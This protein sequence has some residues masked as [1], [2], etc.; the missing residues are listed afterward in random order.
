MSMLIKDEGLIAFVKHSISTL[1]IN[2]ASQHCE[3]AGRLLT[4]NT[5]TNQKM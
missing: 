5:N 3:M 2:F 4:T 1:I